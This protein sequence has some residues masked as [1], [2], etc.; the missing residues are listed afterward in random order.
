[1]ALAELRSAASAKAD[2]YSA[3][4]ER[5]VATINSFRCHL[6]TIFRFDSRHDSAGDTLS[7]SIRENAPT[8]AG[9]CFRS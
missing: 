6:A 3:M 5:F 9:N 2:A 4:K 7:A 8:I 1:M